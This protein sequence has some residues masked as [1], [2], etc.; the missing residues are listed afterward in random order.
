MSSLEDLVG[1]MTLSEL[2][3]F[4]N[5]SVEAI[6]ALAVDRPAVPRSTGTPGDGAALRH[7]GMRPHLRPDK[8]A[9]AGLRLDHVLATLAALGAPAKLDDVRTRTGGSA[10]QVRA[11]LQK[12]AEAGKVDITGERRG[13][14]Y[15]VR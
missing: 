5:T 7:T 14:R 12:L 11:A 8:V 6:V 4:A 9:R 15:T 2:A 13:T 3:R 1:T 10:P